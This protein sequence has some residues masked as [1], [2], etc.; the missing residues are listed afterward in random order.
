MNILV[1]G[2]G[3]PGQQ[4]SK[5]RHNIG[6]LVLDELS[7]GFSSWKEAHKG[8]VSQGPLGE[9]QTTLLKPHTFM[10]SSGESV[11]EA[12]RYKNY[13]GLIVIHDELDI[14]F[15]DVRQKFDGGSAGH[16]GIKNVIK[17]YG[18]AFHRVRC[19]IGRP[20][21][22]VKV[23]DYVLGDFTK[24]EAERIPTVVQLATVMVHQII[25]DITR[26]LKSEHHD[27]TVVKS[28]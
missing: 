23:I 27:D 10:N 24:E 2:L 8:V 13:D 7:K 15:A 26:S 4:Y 21:E 22:G 12:I 9:S 1:V 14:P 25:A 6:W 11:A 18:S 3:N 19:G 16:N 17:H 5:N 28:P 20:P